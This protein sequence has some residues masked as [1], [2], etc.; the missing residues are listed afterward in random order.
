MDKQIKKISRQFEST[1]GLVMQSHRL[2]QILWVSTSAVLLS[3]VF[4]IISDGHWS[5]VMQMMVTALCV[6]M[7]CLWLTYKQKAHLAAT[8]FTL[9]LT[10]L[11]CFLIYNSDGLHDECVLIFP[12]ILLLASVFGT[13]SQFYILLIFL[14]SFLAFVL[15]GH[16]QGWHKV[17]DHVET[18]LNSFIN[19]AVIIIANGFFAFVLASDLRKA[20]IELNLSKKD[21]LEL[22]D[23]LEIRVN[24]RTE[25]FESAN[26]AL[27]ESMDKLEQAMNELVYAEKLASLGSMVAGI[28]HELNTPI[29][30]TLL[31]ATSMEKLFEDV[32]EKI[33]AGNF[34]RTSFDDFIKEGLEMSSLISR[35]TKRAADMVTSFKQVA[36]DQTSEQRRTFDLRDVIEDNAK[37][38]LTNFKKKQIKVIN[39]VPVG[40]ECNSFPGPLGQ[41]LSNIIQNAIIHGFDEKGSG[42][43]TIQAENQ[44]KQV[45]LSI[46]DDGVG[47]PLSVIAHVFDPFFTTKLG[48]GGS[49]LG[50]SISHRIATSVL[51]GDLRV[52]STLGEGAT[53]ILALPKVA[54]FPI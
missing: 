5:M 34:K 49:G 6:F 33:Q 36:I 24:Q 13:R 1:P 22:N 44:M 15:A 8:L 18:N 42:T 9:T 26:T 31:A 3:L 19:I 38:L 35:S 11:A 32:S 23:Q 39:T 41:I 21:L 40:I 25:Q 29:G 10:V 37:S 20:L 54:P 30:N 43:L 47:M 27:Q 51:G 12:A 52:E 17:P 16:I 48:R 4:M 7:L 45:I 50:L 2:M 46:Q 53:F 14:I 28:S